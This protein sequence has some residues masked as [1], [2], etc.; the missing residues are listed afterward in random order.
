MLPRARALSD[1]AVRKRIEDTGSIVL[2]NTPEQF[3]EQIKAELAVYKKVV[4]TAGLKLGLSGHNGGMNTASQS[5][6][7]A[8]IDA[9][10]LEEGLAKNTL[11]AYRR[12]LTLYGRW[13]G[14][15]DRAL[16]AT[17]EADLSRYFAE[18]HTSTRATTANRRLTVFKRYF[19][20]ALR[21]RLITED[22]TLRLQSA[23]QPHAGAQDPERSA[24]GGFA[25][26]Y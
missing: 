21:E 25:G 9:L 18:R 3:A 7:D 6:V 22:P 13:L 8:F 12:D 5:Q 15:Y 16:D 14:Q 2:G 17:T 4:D 23:K 20:W 26:G 10:W 24:S 1:P 19:R 11:E